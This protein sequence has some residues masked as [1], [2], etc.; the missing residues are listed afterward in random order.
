[1]GVREITWTWLNILGLTQ[2]KSHE[3]FLEMGVPIPENLKP[4][5]IVLQDDSQV[6]KAQAV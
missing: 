1:M 5:T 4:W 6:R 2:C 3:V